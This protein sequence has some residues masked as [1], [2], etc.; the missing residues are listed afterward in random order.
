M[1][2]RV[3]PEEKLLLILMVEQHLMEEVLSQA[4]TQQKLIDLR[5]M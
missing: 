1:A 3:L 4:K 5:L 2:M